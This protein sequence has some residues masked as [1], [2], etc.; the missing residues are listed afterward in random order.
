MAPPA[1]GRVLAEAI[2]GG[3]FRLIPGAGHMLPI[4]APD[5]VRR[6]LVDF[7]ST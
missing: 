7:L 6:L 3:Q 4:E 2:P 1:A 5:Q